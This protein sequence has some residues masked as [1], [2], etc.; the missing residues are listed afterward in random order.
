MASFFRRV[1]VPAFILLSLVAGPVTSQDTGSAEGVAILNEAIDR[2]EEGQYEQALITFREILSLNSHAALHG[3]AYFWIA[4]SSIALGRL[5]AAAD[6]LEYFLANYPNNPYYGEGVYENGRLLY[7]QGDYEQAIRALRGY[8]GSYPQAPFVANA[9][10]WIGESL[11]ALGR[12][13][14]A[15]KAFQVVVTQYPR[16]YRS[17]PARYRLSIIDL[18]RRE[19]ELLKLLQWSHEEYVTAV[20]EFREREDSLEAAIADYQRQISENRQLSLQSEVQRLT[21]RVAE[22]REQ[23]SQRGA[24]IDELTSEIQAIQQRSAESQ[25]PAEEEARDRE[26]APEQA[27]SVAGEDQSTLRATRRLIQAK[28]RA[29]A[30]KQ[31]FV[32]E[33]LRTVEEQSVG[34]GR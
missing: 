10:Y 29:L 2:Y 28:Q 1:S 20:D 5:Q 11:F 6:N 21:S 14:R 26:G 18:R 31:F 24:Q 3:D 22:L 16:S 23:L 8:I 12:F 13:D 27:S 7:L 4:K 34:G 15:E 30:L 32:A 17:E 33:L 25:A 19:E 9:Y